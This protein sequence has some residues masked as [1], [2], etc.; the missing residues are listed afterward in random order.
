MDTRTVADWNE[1]DYVKVI[2]ATALPEGVEVGDELLYIPDRDE[3]GD[4]AFEYSMSDCLFHH[5]RQA[6]QE[7]VTIKITPINDAPL[8]SNLSG[9]NLVEHRSPDSQ[10]VRIDLAG[11]S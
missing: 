8:A 2:G 3:S 9:L 7:R 10:K 11:P 5:R 1:L 4:D 6:S